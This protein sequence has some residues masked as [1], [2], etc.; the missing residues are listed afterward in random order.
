MKDK[1]IEI[2]KSWESCPFYGHSFIS[3]IYGSN[4]TEIAEE[5]E[6]ICYPKEFVEWIICFRVTKFSN[7]LYQYYSDKTANW[8]ICNFNKLYQYW[9]KNIDK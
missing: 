3:A 8:E 7:K 9:L 4:Y 5:I 2:L 1:I 6:S